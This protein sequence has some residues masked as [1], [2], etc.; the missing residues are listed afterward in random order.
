MIPAYN[1]AESI[2][3][4]LER[5]SDAVSLEHEILVVVDSPSDSTIAAISQHAYRF[6]KVRTLL[7][8]Y[9]PGPANAIRYGFDHAR[10]ECTVVTMADG[11]DDAWVIDDLVRLVE[12]GCAIAAA[13]RYMPGGAQIGGPRLKRLMSRSAGISL[14]LFA[15]VGTRDATNS[16]KAYST[17]FVKRVGIDSRA[18][19]EIALELV[20]KARRLRLPIAEVPTVW[21]DRDLG[22][23]NF[24]LRTWLPKYLAWYRFTYGRRL[25]V[26]Q[27]RERFAVR[28]RVT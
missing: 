5:L 2:I 24:Q 4:V 1:E 26:A 19:F 23:S 9:G 22:V 11:S 14:N 21:L 3:K 27:I 20:A 17:D 10:A 7:Q 6:P 18:G 8:D 25:N 28:E 16:F 13:S 12:R 15:G